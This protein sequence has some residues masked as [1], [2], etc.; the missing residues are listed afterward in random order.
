M[1]HAW[2]ADLNKEI[3]YQLVY[4]NPLTS[5]VPGWYWGGVLS[6]FWVMCWYGWWYISVPWFR[7]T[8]WSDLTRPVCACVCVFVCVCVWVC[9]CVCVCDRLCMCVC[10]WEREIVCVCVCVFVC[11]SVCEW[12]S[13]SNM[14]CLDINVDVTERFYLSDIIW[15][16]VLKSEIYRYFSHKNMEQTTCSSH[17]SSNIP[18]QH[19][20]YNMV[21]VKCGYT[22]KLLCIYVS[23]NA[24]SVKRLLILE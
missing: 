7:R 15:E 10:V 13:T 19:T 14:D 17:V 1:I 16:E 18:C 2:F 8:G 24:V 11:V 9:V 3:N 4:S 6:L 5:N 21:C 20:R 22:T 12:F 23:L